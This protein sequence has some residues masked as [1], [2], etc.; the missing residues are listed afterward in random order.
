MISKCGATQRSKAISQLWATRQSD[1]ISQR[2][3]IANGGLHESQNEI[4][5]GEQ[6][7]APMAGSQVWCPFVIGFGKHEEKL[8]GL[9][10]T[11]V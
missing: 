1:G 11:G 3:A 8:S 6:L 7:E 2:W 9:Q 10:A 4:A 5:S